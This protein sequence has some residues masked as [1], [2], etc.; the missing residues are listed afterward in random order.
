MWTNHLGSTGTVAACWNVH[1][2]RR[3][4]TSSV[5]THS[6]HFFASH[7]RFSQ[8][9]LG[10]NGHAPERSENS[11]AR[12][13]N[14]PVSQPLFSVVYKSQVKSRIRSMC[15]AEIQPHAPS[16]MPKSEKKSREW[17]NW[18]NINMNTTYDSAAMCWFL[19]LKLYLFTRQCPSSDEDDLEVSVLDGVFFYSVERLDKHQVHWWWTW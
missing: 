6:G 14:A 5:F 7:K 17:M 12:W 11:H 16:T 18:A 1:Q 8:S 9:A 13:D 15:G 2:M 4:S 10:E 19:F 3:L